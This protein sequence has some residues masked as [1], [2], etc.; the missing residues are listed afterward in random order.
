ML[1]KI[2]PIAVPGWTSFDVFTYLAAS[3]TVIDGVAESVIMNW[4]S[5]PAADVSGP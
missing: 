4:L 2:R 3:G 1:K 5:A